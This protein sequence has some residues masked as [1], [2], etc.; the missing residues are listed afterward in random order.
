MRNKWM[1]R[2]ECLTDAE[3]KK[4]LIADCEEG[5]LQ[6]LKE[7]RIMDLERRTGELWRCVGI[8]PTDRRVFGI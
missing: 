4:V 2:L 5:E 1:I 7:A 6:G 3:K 8:V